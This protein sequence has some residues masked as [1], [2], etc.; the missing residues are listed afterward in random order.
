MKKIISLCTCLALCFAV[1]VIPYYY[2]KTSGTN[3]DFAFLYNYTNNPQTALSVTSSGA[4]AVKISCIAK[5]SVVSVNAKTCV[6]RK[7]NG[8]WSRIDINIYDNFWYNCK[9]SDNINTTRTCSITKKG[10]YR[11]KTVFILKSASGES[12]RITQYSS[13][14][15]YKM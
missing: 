6:Q 13:V 9:F 8:R 2:A 15:T 14:I 4:A 12:E 11:S 7:R 10:K 3:K 5:S 1:T